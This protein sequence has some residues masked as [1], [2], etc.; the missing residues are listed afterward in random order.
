VTQ[1]VGPKLFLL[2]V[3]NLVT[4][5][6]GLL[7]SKTYTAQQ[8]VTKIISA[9]VTNSVTASEVGLLKVQV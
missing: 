2:A 8:S 1:K 5:K 6:L 4:P 9:I 3:M 7:P